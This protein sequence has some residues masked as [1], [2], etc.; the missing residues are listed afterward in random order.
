MGQ[1]GANRT[2][3]F[4]HAEFRV[5]IIVR[6]DIASGS[7]VK[8]PSTAVVLE[9]LHRVFGGI[10]VHPFRGKNTGGRIYRPLRRGGKSVAKV[11][12]RGSSL[13]SSIPCTHPRPSLV[14]Y[15]QVLKRLVSRR[16]Y[17]EHRA[18]LT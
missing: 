3:H 7:R 9:E 11:N 5:L 13:R 17:Q 6:L 12:E 4:F 18:N 8:R 14:C 2:H 1:N 10:G 15:L 16:H